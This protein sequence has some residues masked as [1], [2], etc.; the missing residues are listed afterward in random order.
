MRHHSFLQFAYHLTSNMP[1]VTNFERKNFGPK[2]PQLPRQLLDPRGSH[3]G[4]N[5]QG[6][7]F[8]EIARNGL[9]FVAINS[10]YGGY[11]LGDCGDEDLPYRARNEPK[12]IQHIDEN[13]E[14]YPV[15]VIYE[16]PKCLLPYLYIDEYDGAET[17]RLDVTAMERDI[18]LEEVKFL[19]NQLYLVQHRLSEVEEG[20]S[21]SWNTTD[22]SEEVPPNIINRGP[23]PYN[24]RRRR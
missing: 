23:P 4:T 10:H 1:R 3:K 17:L 8:P 21:D 11:S 12:V 7:A 14:E 5:N 6:I 20:P 16:V 2:V 18:A 15:L 24:Q 22:E 13:K 19:K 9:Q